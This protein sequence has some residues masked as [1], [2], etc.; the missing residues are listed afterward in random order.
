MSQENI[1]N[2]ATFLSERELT[3][4]INGPPAPLNGQLMEKVNHY[5]CTKKD[6]FSMGPSVKSEGFVSDA[7]KFTFLDALHMCY[8]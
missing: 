2:Y 1:E 5:N 3:L 7:T 8:G 6:R 4:N